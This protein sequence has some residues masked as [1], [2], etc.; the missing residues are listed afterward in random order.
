MN[1]LIWLSYATGQVIQFRG[2]DG[3]STNPINRVYTAI[4][5]FW[6]FRMIVNCGNQSK[7]PQLKKELFILFL[8]AVVIGII[9]PEETALKWF[10]GSQ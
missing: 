4:L 7:H 2:L 10:M 8:A 6:W 9:Q 5:V 3:L 1:Q